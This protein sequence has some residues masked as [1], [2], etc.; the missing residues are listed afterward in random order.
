VI[1]GIVFQAPA[2]YGAGPI[3]VWPAVRLG[4]EIG[5]VA[6]F[7]QIRLP[8]VT[9]TSTT[10]DDAP[11]RGF[12]HVPNIPQDIKQASLQHRVSKVG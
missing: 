8:F 12:D 10:R 2:I 5:E 6:E 7:A 3:R 1:V 11:Q 9:P 4:A